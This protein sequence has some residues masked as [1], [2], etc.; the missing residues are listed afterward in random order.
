MTFHGKPEV[1]NPS[2]P[3]RKFAYRVYDGGMEHEV[4]AHEIYFYEAGRIG[5]WNY[6]DN[7]ERVLVLGTKAFQVREV[8]GSGRET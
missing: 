8:I 7:D 3:L 5:F 4:S 2:R 6:D 1:P